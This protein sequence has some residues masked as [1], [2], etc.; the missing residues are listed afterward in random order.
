MKNKRKIL[1][2][3]AII[4]FIVGIFIMFKAAVWG[5]YKSCIYDIGDFNEM[6]EG[7]KNSEDI[8][9]KQKEYT[10][11]LDYKWFSV[12]N[13]FADFNH[14]PNVSTEYNETY[15]QYEGNKKVGMLSVGTFESLVDAIHKDDITIYGV[16][17]DENGISFEDIF[18]SGIDNFVKENNIKDD[19]DLIREFSKYD[20]NKKYGVFTSISKL[21]EDFSIRLLASITLP[22]I[23]KIYYI[24]GD[25][26]GY[27]LEI[28][29]EDKGISCYE[30]DLFR[31]GKRY[32]LTVLSKDVDLDMIK[33]VVSTIKLK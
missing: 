26:K 20:Y 27:I 11:Y 22:S 15:Y 19:A 17:G 13:F 3:A 14:D 9:I 31:N 7:Y 10:D 5:V 2:I 1:I 18:Y 8:T 23:N 30:V 29:N 28:I 16:G 21:R 25:F 32:I 33:E 24:N 6:I 12:G 4:L